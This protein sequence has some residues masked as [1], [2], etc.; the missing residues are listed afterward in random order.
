[1]ADYRK[2]YEEFGLTAEAVTQAARASLAR[3]SGV[4]G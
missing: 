2:L 3:A 1:L 4:R